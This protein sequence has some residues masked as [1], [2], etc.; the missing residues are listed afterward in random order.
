MPLR[1]YS[2][3]DNDC[4]SSELNRAVRIQQQSPS[5]VKSSI[6][7]TRIN[8]SSTAAAKQSCI[9]DKNSNS[10][11][12]STEFILEEKA[13]FPKLNMT[14]DE[15]VNI[16]KLIHHPQNISMIKKYKIV[17]KKI[18]MAIRCI[19]KNVHKKEDHHLIMDKQYCE[20]H[21]SGKF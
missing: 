1:C 11:I 17:S 14:T 2:D 19:F 4:M 18:F 8:K 21:F 3:D 16:F 15:V 13:Q 6:T 20:K 12:G 5:E 9:D 10:I 7:I